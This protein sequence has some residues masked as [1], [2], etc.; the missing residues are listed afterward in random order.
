MYPP[1]RSTF[2]ALCSWDDQ[3]IIFSYLP[4]YLGY[5]PEIKKNS[6]LASRADITPFFN[7]KKLRNYVFFT[8]DLAGKQDP[9]DVCIMEGYP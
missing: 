2:L 4:H 6:E 3:V 5:E 9:D 1:L 8:Q 7:H